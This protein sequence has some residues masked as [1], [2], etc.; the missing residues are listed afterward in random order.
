MLTPQGRSLA[1]ASALCALGSLVS[2]QTL[3]THEVRPGCTIPSPPDSLVPALA[4]PTVYGADANGNIIIEIEDLAPTGSWVAETD[5]APFTGSSYFRWNGPD[6]FGTPGV[7]QLVYTIQIDTPGNYKLRLRCRHDNPDSSLENDCW[8]K[9]D[10]EPWEKLFNNDGPASVGV[11]TYQVKLEST[12]L[13][14][15]Y[16]F[17]EGLHTIILS[18][19][20][21]GF[22]MDRLVVY[23]QSGFGEGDF[24]APSP[25]ALDAPTIGEPIDIELDDPTDS[26]GITPG[27]SSILFLSPQPAPGFPCGFVLPGTGEMMVN[28]NFVQVGSQPWAGPGNPVTYTLNI[29]NDNNLV[30]ATAYTQGLWID[31]QGGNFPF[32]LTDGLDLHIGDS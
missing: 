16:F 13:K 25:L 3:G 24:F 12:A 22:K 27:S 8:L 17:E 15:L 10:D 32:T 4:N 2:A 11:W 5:L 30:G 20:S 19:R 14:P 7:G 1:L 23:P 31:P 29:P 18:G 6:L 28:F 9:V 21:F 26:E